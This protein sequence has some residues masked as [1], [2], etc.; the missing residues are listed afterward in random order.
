MIRH[1]ED[2]KDLPKELNEW[3][4][5]ELEEF[6]K[7]IMNC[8]I[9][10]VDH[11]TE[12]DSLRTKWYNYLHEKLS[13]NNFMNGQPPENTWEKRPK[14]VFWWCIYCTN[15][16][17]RHHCSKEELKE[18]MIKIISSTKKY[19]RLTWEFI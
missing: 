12:T 18:Q 9:T 13:S 17:A 19:W 1:F 15:P 4:I 8:Q 6:L 16:Y 11:I 3:A 2:V 7:Y 10:K 14:A 5:N